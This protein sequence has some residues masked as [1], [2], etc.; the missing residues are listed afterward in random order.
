MERK[1]FALAVLF[2]VVL[3]AVAFAPL[4][5]Q[6]GGGAY[7]PW[8]DY[9]EDG[10]IDVSDLHPLG[11]SYG[12][13]GDSTKNVNVTNW[14]Q[15]ESPLFAE[16]LYLRAQWHLNSFILVDED[17]QSVP[18]QIA[19]K[20]DNST[21]IGYMMQTPVYNRSF[22][23]E[24]MPTR[25]YQILG[26]PTVSLT[27]N[28]STIEYVELTLG[29]RVTLLKVL[30]DSSKVLL[31]VF[32]TPTTW[33]YGTLTQH[34]WKVSF[35]TQE[36]LDVAIGAHERLLVRVEI[37]ATLGAPEVAWLSTR[38]MFNSSTDEFRLDIPIVEP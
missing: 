25:A 18:Y 9:N 30:T 8:L 24:R 14:P 27:A 6:Q 22:V 21:F 13:T 2:V 5:G 4:S 28:F 31:G 17:V 35:T 26:K 3:L 12:T 11:G 15:P 36:P 33:I 19:Q 1:Q 23:Y 16:Y 7:D 10:A 32:E 34:N 29:Y 37:L 38:F 20:E